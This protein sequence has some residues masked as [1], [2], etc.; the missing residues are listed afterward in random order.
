MFLQTRMLDTFQ[1]M[2]N[3]LHGE[4]A[5]LKYLGEKKKFYGYDLLLL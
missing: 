3:K 4:L 2:I 5:L 1:K